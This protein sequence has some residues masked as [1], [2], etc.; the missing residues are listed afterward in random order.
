AFLKDVKDFFRTNVFSTN[1]NGITWSGDTYVNIGTADVSG[2]EVG[3][4][5]Y[6][7]SLPA[8][9]NGFGISANYTYIDISTDI[10]AFT[11]DEEL[12]VGGSVSAQDTDGSEIFVEELD[13]L[14]ENTFNITLM[15]EYNA[16]Y[17]RLA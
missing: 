1:Y 15:Y 6:F 10:P 7:D 8:P 17:A 11:G 2:I 4:T 12:G 5:Y 3:G 14:A 9:F 13:G 16:I